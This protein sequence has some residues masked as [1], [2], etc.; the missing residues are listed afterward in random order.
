MQNYATSLSDEDFDAGVDQYF[1]T[2]LSSGQEVPICP[3]GESIK[4]TKANIDEFAAM[5]LEARSKET[6]VQ[7]EAIREGFLQVI[8]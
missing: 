5:V 3:G 2:V 4:V 8:E 7:V 6:T 1:T